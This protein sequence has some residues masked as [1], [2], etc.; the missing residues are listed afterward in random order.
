SF[1]GAGE[2][3]ASG[4]AEVPGAGAVSGLVLLAGRGSS[5]SGAVFMSGASAAGGGSEESLSDA[6]N[7]ASL[8]GAPGFAGLV[9]PSPDRAPRVLLFFL[10]PCA[11]GKAG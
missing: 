3:E 4:E 6:G 2:A 8:F 1:Q 10:L 11:T 9:P 5:V 7:G